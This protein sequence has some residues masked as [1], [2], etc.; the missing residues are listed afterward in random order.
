M[1]LSC[2]MVLRAKLTSTRGPVRPK[3]LGPTCAV[4]IQARITMRFF[5]VQTRFYVGLAEA[6]GHS[7]RLYWLHMAFHR[8]DFT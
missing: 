6:G 2:P 3:M 4:G 1:T 8:S 7:M 5:R